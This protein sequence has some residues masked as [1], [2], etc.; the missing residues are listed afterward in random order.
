M[1]DRKWNKIEYPRWELRELSVDTNYFSGDDPVWIKIEGDGYEEY[2][3]TFTMSVA[4]ARELAAQLSSAA[5]AVER[6]GRFS[7]SNESN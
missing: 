3:Q 7:Q 5:D 1:S 4:E 2:G 6:A